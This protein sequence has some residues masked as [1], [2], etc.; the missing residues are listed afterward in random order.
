MLIHAYTGFGGKIIAKIGK[1]KN[2]YVAFIVFFFSSPLFYYNA[3]H[4]ES[5]MAMLRLEI[6]SQH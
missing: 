4:A 6:E 2:R 1:I 3:S 5:Y